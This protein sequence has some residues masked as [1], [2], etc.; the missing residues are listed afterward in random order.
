MKT[1]SVICFVIVAI[2][3]IYGIVKIDRSA[4]M[5]EARGGVLVRTPFW[6]ACVKPR[7]RRA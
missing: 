7:R 5:C 4:Q 2:L 3:I 6:F 1:L